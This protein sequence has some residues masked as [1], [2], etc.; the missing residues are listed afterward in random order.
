MIPLF[1]SVRRLVTVGAAVVFATLLIG[2]Y[3]AS[4]QGS[5]QTGTA[6]A[7]SGVTQA[8][9]RGIFTALTTA[10]SYSLDMEFFEDRHNRDTVVGSLEALV[11]NTSALE[12]HGGGLDPSFDYLRRFLAGDADQALKRYTDRQYLGSQF[13]LNKLME[14]C[15]TCHS[16][17]PSD[18]AFETGAKF[19]KEANVS[20]MAPV[21]RVNIEIAARQFDN[22]LSTYEEIFALPNMTEQGLRLIGGFEGY[23]KIAI[24]VKNDT[25]RPTRALEK[26]LQRDDVSAGLREEIRGWIGDL[27]ALDLKAGAASPIETARRLVGDA[28]V[29]KKPPAVRPELVRMVAAN[30]LLHRYLQTLSTYDSEASEVYYRLA[31]TESRVS[32]SYWIA[33]T[34][35]LLEKA[36][37]SAPK[38]DYARKAFAVLV[39]RSASVTPV[40]AYEDME[41]PKVDIEELRRLV[42]G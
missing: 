15:A 8:T 25:T 6:G 19:L 32:R 30:T 22:A 17:L 10:Y 26:F 40:S 33:E 39:D 42:E 27:A 37:R 5:P 7:S 4:P 18:Q 29:A 21:D 34:D 13:V 11:A 31:V 23:L 14:N 2:A 28:T 16:R 36:V 3:V 41:V 38:S 35:F 1:S 24:G 9:M 20:S 12:E